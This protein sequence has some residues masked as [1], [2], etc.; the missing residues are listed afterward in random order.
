MNKDDLSF[1]TIKKC[2]RCHFGGQNDFPN[3]VNFDP[4]NCCVYFDDINDD[5]PLAIDY[6]CGGFVDEDDYKEFTK[7]IS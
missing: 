1:R 2:W 4:V 3:C 6:D 7:Y 5:N